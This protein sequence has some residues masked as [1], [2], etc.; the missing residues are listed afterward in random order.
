MPT[1]YSVV[2]EAPRGNL[3]TI[4][5][6]IMVLSAIRKFIK[7]KN[8]KDA[9]ITCRTHRIDLDILHDYDRNYFSIM[10]KHLLIKYL[11]W[12]TWIYLFLVYMKKM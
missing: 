12:N 9:F 6:R 7:Q 1:K 11:K 5:P 2:L 8:Y 3:E 10:W 4:C